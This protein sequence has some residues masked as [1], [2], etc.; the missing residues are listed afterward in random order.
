MPIELT[1]DDRHDLRSVIARSEDVRLERMSDD[2]WFL[3]VGT[4]GAETLV[5][6]LQTVPASPEIRAFYAKEHP[7]R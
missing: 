1:L 5:V 3:R 4:P 2:H 7:R 6:H